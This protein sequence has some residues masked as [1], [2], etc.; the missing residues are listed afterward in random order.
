MKER[1]ESNYMVDIR[2]LATDHHDQPGLARWLAGGWDVTL[3]HYVSMAFIP[4]LPTAPWPPPQ[5]IDLDHAEDVDDAARIIV[6]TNNLIVAPTDGREE[7]EELAGQPTDRVERQSI[8]WVNRSRYAALDAELRSLYGYPQ[9]APFSGL[10]LHDLPDGELRH[11]LVFDLQRAAAL[12]ERSRR[13]LCM[14]PRG[15]R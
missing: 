6:A 11:L 12:D 13:M 9:P 4:H 8:F 3:N 10:R 14:P 5:D 2:N 7:I 1:P 15:P